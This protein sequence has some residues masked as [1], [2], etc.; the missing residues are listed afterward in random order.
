MALM[1]VSPAVARCYTT[2]RECGG[3][4]ANPP[5]NATL[6]MHRLS[7]DLALLSPREQDDY[8]RLVRQLRMLVHLESLV[9]EWSTRT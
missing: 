2:Y 3:L 6:R 9:T 7:N 1:S 8:Y 4:A 5:A